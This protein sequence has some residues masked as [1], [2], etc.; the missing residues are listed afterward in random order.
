MDIL[1]EGYRR[2][3]AKEWPERRA[4]YEA[5]SRDGQSPHALV[6]ACSDSRVDPAMIFGAGPGELFI[7]RNV[8]NLVPPYEPDSN[9]HATSAALEFGVRV[10]QVPH[11]IV[12][13]HA[14]CGGITALL[15][16]LP[17]P[18][19]E[20][21]QPWMRN[22]QDAMERVLADASVVDPQTAC[23]LEAVKLSLANLMTFPWIRERVSNEQ[24]LLHGAT[25]DIRSGI[26]SLLQADGSF[27]TASSQ[28]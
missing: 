17:Y 7:V 11:L 26:L 25:F 20:F 27:T 13:G 24:L 3:R 5:L 15:K 21:L 28:G 2:F 1:L 12:L 4:V 16:G 9:S 18:V 23:E 8:A 10:L 22:A 19:G 14:M 6:V